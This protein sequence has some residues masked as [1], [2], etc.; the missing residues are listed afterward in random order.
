[1]GQEIDRP[2]FRHHDFHRFER[3]LAAEMALLHDYYRSGCFAAAPLRIGLELEAWLVDEHGFPQP[4]NFDFLERANSPGLV[5]ELSQFNVEFNVEHQPLSGAGLRRLESELVES[6]ARAQRVAGEFGLQLAA[7]GILPTLENRHLCLETMS[8]MSRYRALNEQI[9][10][11]RRGRPIRLCIEGEETLQMEHHDVMLEAAATS[12]QLHL[13]VPVQES[14]RYF[15]AAL[16]A[17]GITTGVAANSPLL[18]GK[19]LWS[20]TRIPVFEQAVDL[21]GPFPRVDFGSGYVLESLEEFFLENRACHPV[22]LPVE[23]PAPRE[24][25]PHVRL[26]NGTI[27][28]W[29]RPLIGFDEGGQPH[30]RVE[31]R[32][33]SAG[34]TLCDMLANIAF[35]SGLIHY[36][37]RLEAAPETRIPF[38]HTLGNFRAAARHGLAAQVRWLEGRER[39][40]R[41]LILEELLEAAHQG[42]L[43]LQIESADADRY[44]EIIAKRVQTGQNGALWQAEFFKRCGRDVTVLTRE[45]L[46]WQQE[47]RPVHEWDL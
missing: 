20:E 41:Q 43:A 19:L 10:R 42:L 6:W 15:N 36:L 35:A 9:L 46:G 32:V 22:L 30:L 24:H 1:M 4:R 14:V 27:W 17:S 47:G 34:P 37:A 33:M 23:L 5:P 16:I 11:F 28:R 26:H 2:H 38:E 45:Y 21:G 12:L 44:L 31:H 18:F 3:H 39:S 8:L 13:Q 25:L 40:L 29:N 7:I